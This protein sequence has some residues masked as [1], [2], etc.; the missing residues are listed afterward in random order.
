M[1]RRRTL[2]RAASPPT[3]AY[4]EQIPVPGDSESESDD[5]E[6]EP[7]HNHH[8]D[9]ES[10]DDSAG[11]DDAGFEMDFENVP[12]EAAA[13]ME[14][15]PPAGGCVDEEVAASARKAAK[16]KERAIDP[17]PPPPPV[18]MEECTPSTQ[19]KTTNRKSSRRYRESVYRPILTIHRSQGFVW[20]QDLFVPAYIK[21]RYVTSTSPPGQSCVS[22]TTTSSA[23]NPYDAVEVVEIRVTGRELDD[24]FPPT[25]TL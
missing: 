25:S 16:G 9:D 6:R 21:D 17:P 12:Q 5:D 24:L 19:R 3:W 18:A 2:G 15:D 13:A 11:D 22:L 10:D 14:V 7:Q 20:N 8:S 4:Y 1:F 23:P